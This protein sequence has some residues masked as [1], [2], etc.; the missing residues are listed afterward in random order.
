M[1]AE[2]TLS[3][4]ASESERAE[5]NPSTLMQEDISTSEDQKASDQPL[6]EQVTG[7]PPLWV[8]TG[9]HKSTGLCGFTC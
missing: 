9:P 5:S 6:A 1:Q 2:S 7:T 4:R 3:R 8:D